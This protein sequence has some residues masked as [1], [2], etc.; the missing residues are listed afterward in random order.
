MLRLSPPI[1]VQRCMRSKIE[2]DAFHI[3]EGKAKG[4]G[5]AH[6]YAVSQ[7]DLN[8]RPVKLTSNIVDSIMPERQP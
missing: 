1:V 5:N 3:E 7:Y 2:Q 4:Q 8:W 6:T